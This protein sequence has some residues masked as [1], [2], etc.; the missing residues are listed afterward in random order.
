[1]QQVAL[2]DTSIL[3]LNCGDRIIMDA[4]QQVAAS[5][6][7]NAYFIPIPTHEYVTEVSY[8]QMRDSQV[9]LV[10]GTNLLSSNMDQYNQWKINQDYANNVNDIVL[11]GVGWWQYQDA[12][13]EY[14]SNLFKSVLSKDKIHSVRDSYT[15]TKLNEIGIQN[16]V[17]TGCPTMWSLTNAHCEQ[18]PTAQ[19]DHVVTTVTDYHADKARDKEMLLNLLENYKKVFIWLQSKRDLPYLEK[20]L[21]DSLNE[22]T[23]IPPQV[24]KFN[25]LLASDLSLDYVGTRLHAGIRALQHK[26]RSLIISVDNRA[27]EIGKDSHLNVLSRSQIEQLTERIINPFNT[28]IQLLEDNILI[29]KSQFE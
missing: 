12:P 10:C 1:M 23:I 13:N 14:T 17:N 6:F 16:V 27:A 26:R 3:S 5:I 20:V 21:G 4:C 19:A 22:F 29:W 9:S 18:I 7:P 8:R 11:F 28:S 2:L 15:R 25:S 24:E